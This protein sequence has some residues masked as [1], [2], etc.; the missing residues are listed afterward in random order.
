[1]LWHWQVIIQKVEFIG[2]DCGKVYGWGLGYNFRL[3]MNTTREID[4]PTPIS[5]NAKIVQV[6]AGAYHSGEC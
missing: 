1:M 6:A 5:V 4:S 2:I 3:G